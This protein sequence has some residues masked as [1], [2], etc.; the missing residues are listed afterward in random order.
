M[1][2]SRTAAGLALLFAVLFALPG[3]GKKD[4]GNSDTPSGG[5]PTAP[6][7]MSRVNTSAVSESQDKLKKIAVAMH[8]Y[9]D[10]YGT[11]PNAIYGPDRKTPGLSWRV[12]LLPYIEHVQLYQQFK[13]N[14]PWDSEHNKKL[15]E[16]M[17]AVYGP[18]GGRGHSGYTYYRG[19]AGK[20]AT[21]LPH[22]PN[23]LGQPGQPVRGRRI[24]EFSDGTSNTVM[25]AEAAEA[26]PWTKPDELAFDLKGPLPKL[27]GIFAEGANA[28]YGDGSVRFLP[29]SIP[30][31]VLRAFITPNMGEVITWDDD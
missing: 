28:A 20:D 2:T 11:F 29:A 9:H 8:N 16:K 17:P 5:S 19:F 21:F 13:L 4:D 3:C 24:T 14:E 12:A 7:G 10:A 31:N 22:F 18:P 30:P 27:G 23:Q 6:L 26:V 25:I 15:I 1:F